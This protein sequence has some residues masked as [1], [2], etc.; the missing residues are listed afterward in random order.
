MLAT[1]RIAGGQEMAAIFTCGDAQGLF[2]FYGDMNADRRV[3]IADFGFF[4]LAFLNQAN[5][6]AALDFN[7]DGRDD[8]VALQTGATSVKLSRGNGTFVEFFIGGNPGV[9][10]PSLGRMTQ[11]GDFNGDGRADLVRF[12]DV[13]L[14]VLTP[15]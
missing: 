11:A 1:Q 2:R 10:V 4:S 13:A 3:D 14:S 8:I 7:S 5:Y 15:T 9:K 12:G 6:N